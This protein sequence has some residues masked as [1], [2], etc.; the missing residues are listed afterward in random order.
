[1]Y[2]LGSSPPSPVLDLPPIRFIAIASVLCASVLIEPSDIAP[3]VK[4]LTISLAGSTSSSEIAFIGSSFEHS[5]ANMSLLPLGLLA[6]AVTGAELPAGLSWSAAAGNLL[7]STLGNIIGGGG[8]LGLAY[9][10]LYLRG[11]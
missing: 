5:I 8:G 11:R 2:R 10:A 6:Q 4:R 3:V 7:W 1:M 9:W